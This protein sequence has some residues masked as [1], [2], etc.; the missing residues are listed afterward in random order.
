MWMGGVVM[1]GYEVKERKLIINEDEAKI[2][3]FIYEQ[4]L[5]SESCLEIAYQLNKRGYRTKIKKLKTGK[6]SG[7]QMFERKAIQRIL[8]NPYYKGCVTHRGAVYQGEHEGIIDEETWNRVQEVF[9]ANSIGPRERKTALNPS[10][11]KGKIRCS[12]CD[13]LMRHSYSNNHGLTYRYYTCYNHLKYKTCQAQHKN[14]PAEPVERAVIEEM[15]KIVKSPEVVININ[16]LADK[17]SDLC[18]DDLM[19]ALKNL[20][21]VWNHLYQAEQTKIVRMLLDYVEIRDDGVKLHL[22]LNGFDNLFVE[23][24]V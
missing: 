12:C 3:R 19:L 11:L 20:N 9:K 2:I 6:A 10:F 24:S 22:N 18:R 23:L 7:G 15:L 5:A 8:Q 13:V 14:V 4:F 1:L 16:N 21:D 17:N